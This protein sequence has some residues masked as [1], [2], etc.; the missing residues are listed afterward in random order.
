MANICPRCKSEHIVKRKVIWQCLDCLWTFSKPLDSKA[1]TLTLFHGDNPAHEFW[2]DV[3]HK[4][5]IFKNHEEID[6]QIWKDFKMIGTHTFLP[7]AVAI[8]EEKLGVK[9]HLEYSKEW[10][11]PRDENDR[12][13]LR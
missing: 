1:P 9:V 11:E 6:W 10:T 7:A 13:V 3:D 4:L 8:A 12:M 5:L 2:E